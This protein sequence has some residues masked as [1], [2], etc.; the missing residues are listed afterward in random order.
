MIK[1]KFELNDMT[2]AYR[3]RFHY[4]EIYVS[5]D[6]K[7]D[8]DAVMKYKYILD[9]LIDTAVSAIIT[10]T[11]FNSNNDNL[12]AKELMS[13]I[14]SIFGN[15][16]TRIYTNGIDPDTGFPQFY[17][18]FDDLS[19]KDIELLN[20]SDNFMRLYIIYYFDGTLY[21]DA[22]NV[23]ANY[24]ISY[25]QKVDKSL[26]NRHCKIAEEKFDRYTMIPY[27]SDKRI[28]LISK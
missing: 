15:E 28:D 26:I 14:E 16:K 2:N 18:R 24:F 20:I 27:K 4:T 9:G 25:N 6:E 22:D 21:K 3:A 5:D 19:E 7:M 1:L 13:R 17:L 23:V 12:T 8:E 11:T 10:I